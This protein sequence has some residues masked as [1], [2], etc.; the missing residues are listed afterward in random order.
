MFEF[1]WRHLGTVLGFLLGVVLVARM[2]RQER[3]PSVTFAWLLAMAFV[4]YV[5]VP[6]YLLLGGRKL[7][8]RAR[9]KR[10][11]YGTDGGAAAADA[12][13]PPEREGHA[14]ELLGDGVLARSRLFALIDAARTSIRLQTF[15][16]GRDDVGRELVERLARRAREG[17][18][19]RLLV[20]ALGSLRTRGSFLDPL[21]RAGGKVSVFMP[22]LPFHRT[23]SANL[24]N[25]RK[26]AVID[27]RD[28]WLGGMNVVAEEMGPAPT[29][30]IDAA[31]WLRGPCV[32][33]LVRIF[34]A[35]WAFA[36]GG[37]QPPAAAP[38]SEPAPADATDA[39]RAA[40]SASDVAVRVAAGGPD[41][42]GEPLTDGFF[43]ALAEA[44][45]RIWIVTPYF[46]PDEGLLRVLRYQALRGV[47]VRLVLPE[48]S[49]HLLADLARARFVR[50][51]VRDGVDVRLVPERMVHAKLLVLDDERAV[52]GS[53]NLDLRSLYVNYELAL[54]LHGR[55]ANA[56]L[57]AWVDELASDARRVLADQVRVPGLPRQLAEDV[58]AL[59]SPLL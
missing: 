46:I 43:A 32:A 56:V 7:A 23:W 28:A 27:G 31:S 1:T 15:I 44:H 21:R 38:A 54:F 16:L 59:V 55:R 11:L 30:W 47:D 58:A 3:S 18:D 51:L 33:D 37:E 10:T 53:A 39:R 25:H 45:R 41:V 36:S 34:D 13:A 29:R 49:N 6:A 4:P 52:M 19:V 35:D 50:R 22:M 17:V 5:G 9:H 24:R 40:V 57:A 48:R 20:D 8:E 12:V 14:F 2:L 42:E 26:L